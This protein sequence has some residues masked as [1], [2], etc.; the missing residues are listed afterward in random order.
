MNVSFVFGG[1]AY[2][3]RPAD[4]HRV[5]VLDDGGFVCLSSFIGGEN[6]QRGEYRWYL[7]CSWSVC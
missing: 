1:I 7:A 2:P 3:I 6:F 5:V 4:V